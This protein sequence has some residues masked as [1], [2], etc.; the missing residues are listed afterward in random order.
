MPRQNPFLR[1]AS[2]PGDI[3][4][5]ESNGPIT[6]APPV[7]SFHP[8]KLAQA[9][10]SESALKVPLKPVAFKNTQPRATSMR[11]S[12]FIKASTPT[13]STSSPLV[14]SDHSNGKETQIVNNSEMTSFIGL[15]EAFTQKVYIEGY[16]MRYNDT[17]CSNS[18]TVSFSSDDSQQKKTKTKMFVELS[19]STL[20]LWDA[21]APGSSIMPTYTQIMDTATIY[22]ESIEGG[23]KKT[24]YV[25]TLCSNTKSKTMFE[26]SDY[27]TMVRWVSAIRLSCFEKQRLHQLFTHKLLISKESEERKSMN[28]AYLQVRVPGT[29]LWKKYWVVLPDGKKTKANKAQHVSLYGS[30]RSKTPLLTLSDISHVYAIYPESPQL[31]EKGSMIRVDCKVNDKEETCWFMADKCEVTIQWLFSMFDKFKLYGRPLGLLNDFL[32]PSSLNFGEPMQTSSGVQRLFLEVDQVIKTMDIA[33]IPVKH[34]EETFMEII[35]NSQ[36]LEPPVIRPTGLRANSLPLITVI[37]ADGDEQITQQR[38]S[39]DNIAALHGDK[40]NGSETDSTNLSFKFARH[41]A[42]SSDESD[43]DDEDIEDE[44]EEYDSDNEPIGRKTNSR[45]NSTVATPSPASFADSLIPDFDFGNGFDVPKDV[46]AAAVAAAVVNA[47]SSLSSSS[48]TTSNSLDEEYTIPKKHIRKLSVPVN[49]RHGSSLNESPSSNNQESSLFGDFDLTGDFGKFL[50]LPMEQHQRKY[51]LP[52]KL[53]FDR[54]SESRST[55]SST[56]SS[57]HNNSYHNHNRQWELDWNNEMQGAESP[58]HRSKHPYDDD[59]YDSDFD[60]PLIPS[61][62]DHFAPQ[63][64]L[65]DTYLGEHLSAKEQVEYAK[66]TGQPLIQMPVKKEGLPQGGLVG[67]ISQREK[68]KKEG[69]GFRVAERVNQHYQDRIEREKERRILEQRQQQIMKHQVYIP[70]V[71]N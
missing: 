61:L 10:L 58:Q 11:P 37:S 65:L 63:N 20:I 69:N 35:K 33:S 32:N 1:R 9:S 67:V 71:I 36:S 66:A 31:I 26:T 3:N 21:E 47:S 38:S 4:N 59:S 54:P 68:D 45:T 8:G 53:S 39:S 7:P 30:K 12:R 40:Q 64:S 44:E 29:T 22:G 15:F 2:S 13:S 70:L 41:V 46:T 43:Q 25:F 49:A 6:S 17:E 24:K 23:N 60:G 34:I 19:G 52:A 5:N 16:L 28:S 50:D 42:D 62:G 27:A 48:V 55:T 18:S 14:A 51:S 56:H 57:H